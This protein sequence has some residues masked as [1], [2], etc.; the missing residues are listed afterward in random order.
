MKHTRKI[1]DNKIFRNIMEDPLGFMIVAPHDLSSSI[2]EDLEKYLD[3]SASY[4]VAMEIAKDAHHETK[5][6]HFHILAEMTKKNYDTFRKTILVNKMKL[7][8]QARNGHPRQYGMVRNIRSDTKLMSYTL[9]HGNYITKNIDLK[10]IQEYYEKSYIKNSPKD[11]VQEIMEYLQTIDHYISEV[12]SMNA[13]GHCI[14]FQSIEKS[15]ISFY[16][17][18]QINK[19]VS[20]ST[21]KS[22]TT[23]YLMYHEPLASTQNIYDYIYY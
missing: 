15:I 8:G 7:S 20:K 4:I 12:H 21:L 19:P 6:Q 22:L 13:T 10:T 16:V 11:F 23:R 17:I 18:N 2:I 3:P 9:K 5:G 14:D 1:P